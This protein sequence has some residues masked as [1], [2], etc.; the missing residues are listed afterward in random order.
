MRELLERA[1]SGVVLDV[2]SGA[3]STLDP[4]SS[5]AVTDLRPRFVARVDAAPPEGG[6][7][8]DLDAGGL[9]FA[10]GAFDGAVCNHVLEHVRRPEAL[11]AEIGRVLRPDGLLVAVVPNGWAFSEHLFRAW[12]ALFPRPDPD[13]DRHV[14]RFTRRRFVAALED[15]GFE[16]LRV[17]DVG[18]TYF[19]LRKHP[20][21][22]R[23]LTA[24]NRGLRPLH[25]PTFLYGWHVVARRR[26]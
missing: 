14:Q 24:F 17:T 6:V 4:A 23:A 7:R 22:Q 18:E 10:G 9:P 19:W 5:L 3:G 20:L 26:R 8:A 25:P 21:A 16:P 12:H 15:A 11:L 1:F 13:H 2:G